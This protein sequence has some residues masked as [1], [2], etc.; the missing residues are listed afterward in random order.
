LAIG[1][2]PV[3]EELGSKVDKYVEI[4]SNSMQQVARDPPVVTPRLTKLGISTGVA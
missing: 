2:V 1:S 4:L 3:G